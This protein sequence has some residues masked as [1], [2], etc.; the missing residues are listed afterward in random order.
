L[1]DRYRE[2]EALSG[3]E[4]RTVTDEMDLRV[5][6]VGTAASETGIL[7]LGEPHDRL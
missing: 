3:V 4:F 1:G 7:K 2:K 6:I 5:E